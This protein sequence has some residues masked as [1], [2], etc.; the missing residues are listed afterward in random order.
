[1]SDAT[2]PS[3][4]SVQRSLF[5]G[6]LI[7]L[8]VGLVVGII[9]SIIYVRLNPPVYQGGAYPNELT[10]AYQKHY[11]A[12]VVDSYIVNQ[13]QQ[14]AQERLKSFDAAAK[15]QALAERSAA[16][17]A[18]GRPA[19]AQLINDLAVK[20][21]SAEGWSDDAIKSVVDDL[22]ARYQTEP[23]RAQALGTFNAALLGAAAPAPAEAPPPADQPAAQPPAE[24]PAAPPPA[25]AGGRSW[26]LYLLCCLLLGL[27]IVLVVLL[28]GARQR[29]K[30]PA[31]PVIEWKGEGPPPLKVWNGTYTLGQDMYDE[32]FTIETEDNVFLGE[33]GMAIFDSISGTS[34]KQV[35][36]FD[37]GLFDKTDITTRSQILMTEYAY[38]NDA[39]RAKVDTNPQA[40]PVLAEPGKEFVF[41]SAAMR[42]EGKI[43]DMAY[44]DGNKYFEKLKVQ[45]N[46]FVK[47]GADL[48]KGQ[49]DVPDQFL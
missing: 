26:W 20:L 22:T 42:V 24:Q 6:A 3:M 30:V 10:S 8:V 34:P 5:I 49:M 12:M 18:A 27:L 41:E 29:R 17:V 2:R 36:A 47:E 14:V 1:M 13:E 46:L 48:K 28:L 19:E 11:L 37:V 4:Q 44:G 15:I 31:R 32:F 43:E 9:G 45:L 21:K 25:E 16:Y 40:D 7:G 35:V 39:M 38:N 33:C 23:A